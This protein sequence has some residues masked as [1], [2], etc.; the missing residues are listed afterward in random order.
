MRRKREESY[1]IYRGLAI[2]P[3]FIVVFS[4]LLLVILYMREWKPLYRVVDCMRKKKR[5]ENTRLI[6]LNL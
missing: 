1:W 5:E 6:K 4:H 3:T 2:V